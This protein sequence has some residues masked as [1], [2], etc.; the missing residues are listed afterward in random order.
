QEYRGRQ[1]IRGHLEQMAAGGAWEEIIHGSLQTSGKTV[2]YSKLRYWEEARG[3]GAAPIML[4][5]EA[6][7][8]GG[9]ITRLGMRQS[10]ESDLRLRAGRAA[11]DLMEREGQ[12]LAARDVDAAM[13]LMAGNAVV[14]T[15]QR[16]YTGTAEIREWITGLFAGGFREE[17][18][19]ARQVVGDRVVQT[20]DV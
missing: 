4:L 5:V 6:T 19:G 2:T 12:A 17:L 10:A 13:A 18:V 20:V 1:A 15:P 9:R 3:L 14:R 7:V 16:T 11:H 8:D